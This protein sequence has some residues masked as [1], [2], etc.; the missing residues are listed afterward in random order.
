MRPPIPWAHGAAGEAQAAHRL[1]ERRGEM[2]TERF[3]TAL[4]IQ[5]ADAH[6]LDAAT[7]LRQRYGRWVAANLKEIGYGG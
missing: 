4:R 6:D 1:F 3:I 7:F 2:R 5:I